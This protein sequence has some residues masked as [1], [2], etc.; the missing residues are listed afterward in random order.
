MAHQ[1]MRVG[2]MYCRK[3]WLA[4]SRM[5]RPNPVI[6]IE[7][8]NVVFLPDQG[9]ESHLLN[10]QF[11]DESLDT[12]SRNNPLTILLLYIGLPC[13]ALILQESVCTRNEGVGKY[14]CLHLDC[15]VSLVTH[16]HINNDLLLC[17][18]FCAHCTLCTR[19]MQQMLLLALV[20]FQ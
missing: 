12:L 4:R 3:H 20:Y 18:S 13:S 19:E 17:K 10:R 7:V 11:Q 8:C 15:F 16:R 1:E 9:K 14:R 5:S 6:Q 2:V